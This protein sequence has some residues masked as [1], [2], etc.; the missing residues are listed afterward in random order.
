VIT[1]VKAAHPGEKVEVWFEDEARFGQQGTLTHVWA[2]KG[3]RPV[4]PKQVG[5]ANVQVLTAVCPATGRAEG[6]IAEKLNSQLTQL[7]LDQL[8][9][10][11]PKG[12]HVVL[13]WDGAG[14]HTANAIRPPAN[15]TLVRLPPYSPELNPVERLWHYIREHHWSNTVYAGIRELERAAMCGWRSVCLRDHLVQSVCRCEYAS[16]G[17]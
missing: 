15:I 17:S 6:L 2:P 10:T 1:E 8:S 13:V 12:T 16:A 4:A 11:I 5:Y 3:S 9:G 7:F 14:W